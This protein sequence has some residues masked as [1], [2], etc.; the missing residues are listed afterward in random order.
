MK[1]KR[2]IRGK[3]NFLI[4]PAVF[5]LLVSVFLFVGTTYGK[6]YI[7]E[8]ASFEFTIN[9]EDLDWKT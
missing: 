1:T 5:L 3:K 6:Y 7:E 8:N 4:F 2:N 9:Q